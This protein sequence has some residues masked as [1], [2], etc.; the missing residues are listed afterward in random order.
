L[1]EKFY[2]SSNPVVLDDC[3]IYIGDKPILITKTY[4]FIRHSYLKVTKI[5]NDWIEDNIRDK[6][7]IKGYFYSKPTIEFGLFNEET[8]DK[9][10]KL[11]G[12]KGNSQYQ[13]S[14]VSIGRTKNQF[15]E[16]D[17]FQISKFSALDYEIIHIPY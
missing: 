1:I 3:F 13:I 14:G 16:S 15:G 10:I 12:N 5:G 4:L 11:I 2:K 7:S 17:S 8:Y 9:D 6:V